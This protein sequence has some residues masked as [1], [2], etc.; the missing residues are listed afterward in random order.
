MREMYKVSVEKDAAYR[1]L[2]PGG[3][4]TE[5]CV[6]C[7]AERVK[8]SERCECGRAFKARRREYAQE[9]AKA[10]RGRIG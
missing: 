10:N 1:E 5:I 6:A 4:Y 8:N 2:E 9:L 7:G 3:A